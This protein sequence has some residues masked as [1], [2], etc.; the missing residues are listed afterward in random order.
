MKRAG[1]LLLAVLAFGA[2]RY[3]ATRER[4]PVVDTT[5]AAW[6]ARQDA[7]ARARVFVADPVRSRAP[8]DRNPRDPRP[9]DEDRAVACDYVAKPL[10]GTTPKFDC[11]LGDGTVLKVK[12]GRTPE[13]HAEV[14]ATRLL[15][16][17]G[18]GADHVSYVDAVDCRGCPPTPFRTQQFARLFFLSRAVDHLSDPEVVRRFEHVAVERK[19]EGEEVEAGD[20][21]GWQWSELTAVD[22]ARGGASRADLD[23]LRLMAVLL[24]H[25]DNKSSNQ[26]LVCRGR[27]AADPTRCEV[28]VLMLQDLGSTFGPRKLNQ[29]GWAQYPVWADA[30]QCRVSM[31]DLPYDGATFVDADITEEG[32]VVLAKRLRSLPASE[33]EQL[34][35]AAG[36]P[37]AN[38]DDSSSAPVEWARILA[39]KIAQIADRPPCPR[40]ERSP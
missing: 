28:P 35:A 22:P 6:G 27:E 37:D 10:S 40:R 31:R 25:W 2:L 12:Y 24:G 23:A 8:L 4:E 21:E 33:F 38:G 9:L 15:A 30:E 3:V 17:L 1:F 32:R 36:F 14:A 13:V 26:R 19:L 20:F 7:L 29:R 18:F 34:F 11:R 16:A 39:D 5:S